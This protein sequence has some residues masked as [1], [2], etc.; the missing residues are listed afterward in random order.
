MLQIDFKSRKCISQHLENVA[1]QQSLCC[2]LEL[3][4]SLDLGK[5]TSDNPRQIQSNIQYFFLLY[6]IIIYFTRPRETHKRQPE[7][8]L[9]RYLES[10]CLLEQPMI[11]IFH[12]PRI[13]KT[14]LKQ[15][16]PK[17]NLVSAIWL[18]KSS[19]VVITTIITTTRDNSSSST[20][21]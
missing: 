19:L 10:I 9:V 15:L 12:F 18:L 4:I 11:V 7:T 14:I 17:C 8:N 16:K 1:C 3:L 6:I 13:R 20:S 2:R 21:S 5:P